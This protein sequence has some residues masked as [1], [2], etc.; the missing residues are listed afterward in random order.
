[1]PTRNG[2]PMASIGSSRAIAKS[3]LRARS[4]VMYS[5][6]TPELAVLSANIRAI[7]AITAA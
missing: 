6:F 7:G 5:S 3:R 1:M 2:Q 4:G